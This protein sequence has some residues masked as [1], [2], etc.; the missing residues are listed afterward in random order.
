MST[1]TDR[2]DFNAA[3]SDAR[4]WLADKDGYGTAQQNMA[5]CFLARDLDGSD[6]DE[7]R[8]SRDA[9][10][11]ETAR[12]TTER[13]AALAEAAALRMTLS[14]LSAVAT[15]RAKGYTTDRVLA[16][17]F[18]RSAPTPMDESTREAHAATQNTNLGTLSTINSD[19]ENIAQVAAAL[20]DAVHAGGLSADYYRSADDALKRLASDV[21]LMGGGSVPAPDERVREL[22]EDAFGAWYDAAC[23]ENYGTRARLISDAQAAE[24][25]ALAALGGPSVVAKEPSR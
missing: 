19:N 16:L 17:V 14:E 24:A 22:V 10:L 4:R 11:D 8:E 5:R 18:G 1:E 20:A 9:A 23:S 2:P 21:R 12:L 15:L 6:I 25:K 7:L 13:D 3:R